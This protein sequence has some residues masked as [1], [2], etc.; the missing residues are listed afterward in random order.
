MG[1][2]PDAAS[3][4]FGI[5]ALTGD[6]GL[7]LFAYLRNVASYVLPTRTAGVITFGCHF[8]MDAQDGREIFTIRPWDGVGKRIVVR[9]IGFDV[10]ASFGVIRELRFD[11]RKRWAKIRVQNEAD[12][13]METQIAVRGLWGGKVE[14]E[15]KE[16]LVEDGVAIVSKRMEP[17][18]VEEIEL[19]VIE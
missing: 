14:F 4:Q 5:S 7:S 12:R 1:F 8:E 9:Q 13:A 3:K 10:R 16:A 15:G 2:C 19:K 11:T 17:G 6:V 18:A